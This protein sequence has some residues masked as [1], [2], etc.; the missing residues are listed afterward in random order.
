MDRAK[1]RHYMKAYLEGVLPAGFVSH[2]KD[3][4]ETT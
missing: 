4:T 3:D 1:T 2:T